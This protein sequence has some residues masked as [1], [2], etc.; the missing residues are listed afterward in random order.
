MLCKLFHVKQQQQQQQQLKMVNLFCMN[1]GSSL[2]KP[3][4]VYWKLHGRADFCQALLYAGNV[5]YDLDDDTANA[6]PSTKEESPYGQL[7]YLKHG[8]YIIGQGGAINRY[9]ARLGGLFPKD[10]IEAA[11]CD[12]HIEEV[13]DIFN[14][15]YKP[16]RATD[17][18]TKVAHWKRIEEEFLPKHFALLEAYLT[19]SGKKFLGGDKVNAADVHF[20][21][22]YNL[23]D[24]ASVDV[25]G[26]IAKYPKLNECL[27]ETKLYGD[28]PNFP[29]KS[30]YFSS[31][32]NSEAF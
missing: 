23:Y 26:V 22:V 28:L 32:V 11:I 13:M 2:P 29:E 4:L 19:K 8:P 17:K 30:L 14:E 20:F 18:E 12:M 21:A 7:P 5:S 31:D 1:G 27:E 25:E 15:I 3:V 9:C 16:K 24:K 6:W 10:P